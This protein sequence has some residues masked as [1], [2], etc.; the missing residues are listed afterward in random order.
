MSHVFYEADLAN[1]PFLGH[2]LLGWTP[3]NDRIRYPVTFSV[4]QET[5]RIRA[6][7]AAPIGMS[8]IAPAL[9]TNPGEHVAILAGGGGIT[10]EFSRGPDGITIAPATILSRLLPPFEVIHLGSVKPEALEPGQLPDSVLLDPETVLKPGCRFLFAL[11]IQD[12]CHGLML[13][14]DRALLRGC[15]AAFLMSYQVALLGRPADLPSLPDELMETLLEA[16]PPD[17]F[18]E[19][20]F[21]PREHYWSMEFLTQVAGSGGPEIEPIRWVAEGEHGR[22][23]EGW[24]W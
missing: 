13:S 20:R 22:W 3:W 14:E 11:S 17:T 10:A 5:D 21:H 12:G 19:V 1:N 9:P 2:A 23:R 6:L 8:Q 4:E 15:L 16:T 7:R 18:H 24:S